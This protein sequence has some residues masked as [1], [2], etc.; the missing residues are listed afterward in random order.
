MP[1]LQTVDDLLKY[2]AMSMDHFMA[3]NPQ[4]HGH[5][6]SVS[7]SLDELVQ[8]LDKLDTGM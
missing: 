1:W 6:I 8:Y 5:S 2:S 3:L 4:L 7:T